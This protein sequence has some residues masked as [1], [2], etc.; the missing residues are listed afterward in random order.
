MATPERMGLLKKY[1][2]KIAHP[3]TL[4]VT[5]T[6]PIEARIATTTAAA[7]TDTTP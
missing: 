7:V 3:I 1:E 2:A 5:A 6:H 4:F